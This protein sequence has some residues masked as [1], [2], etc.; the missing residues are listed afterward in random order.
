MELTFRYKQ[1]L[2]KLFIMTFVLS[3]AMVTLSS[4]AFADTRSLYGYYDK[5]TD[6][7]N[8]ISTWFNSTV[9]MNSWSNATVN[10]SS[11]AL[12]YGPYPDEIELSTKFQFTGFSLQIGAPSGVTVNQGDDSAIYKTKVINRR[13]N[14]Q[15]YHNISATGMV[16]GY[17]QSVSA[18]FKYG[19]IHYNLSAMDV[20]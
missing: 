13:E 1:V 17:K 5:T 4:T 9:N 11:S 3:F 12:A 18:S 19:G 20:Y 10:G 2:K 14:V 16:T 8:A 6:E 7:G 15:N